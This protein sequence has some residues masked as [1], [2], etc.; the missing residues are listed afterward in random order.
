MHVLQII[1]QTIKDVKEMHAVPCPAQQRSCLQ[2]CNMKDVRGLKM[3]NPPQTLP[4]LEHPVRRKF[5]NRCLRILQRRYAGVEHSGHM[6]QILEHASS[7]SPDVPLL[8]PIQLQTLF[9]VL[10]SILRSTSR[11]TG[12][13]GSRL[14]Q[15]TACL[16]TYR[17]SCVCL[18]VHASLIV[19]RKAGSAVLRCGSAVGSA[20]S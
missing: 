20:G 5:S 4:A 9:E 16:S 10:H 18:P 3:P 14:A 15:W 7:L 2:L 6:H 12:S 19:E 13:D 1:K 11:K 8:H 17:M